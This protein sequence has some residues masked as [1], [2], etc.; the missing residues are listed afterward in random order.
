[1]QSIEI[2]QIDAFTDKVFHGNPAAICLLTE[3]LND[4]L[5]Q[6]I[7]VENNLS[8]T[9]FVIENDNAFEI[10]WFTPKGEVSLC[11]HATLA[12]A[13]LLFELDKCQQDIVH[14]SSLSGSL[15]VKKENDLLTMDFPRLYFSPTPASL[16]NDIIDKPIVEAFESD[17]DYLV[18]LEDEN[19][20]LQTQVKLKT[21]ARLPKRGLI[22]SAKGNESDFYSRCFY[23]KHNI[24]E[25]PVTGSAHCVLT[26]FWSE[27]LNKKRLTATKGSVRKGE[28]ICE[29]LND[30]VLISGNCRWYM[31]GHLFI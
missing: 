2:F 11:G 18:I 20:V 24:F 15:Y 31:K 30:R 3:W 7:A 12:A 29:L 25:D 21:L 4:E 6:A 10:R 1:M 26:P 27:K 8:E 17:L 9:A 28:L 5:L 16:F 13:F 14:F 23:P 22:L 19:Q